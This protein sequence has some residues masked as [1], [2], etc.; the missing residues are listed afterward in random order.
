MIHYPTGNKLID[1]AIELDR[2]NKRLSDIKAGKCDADFKA[3]AEQIIDRHALQDAC[4][5]LKKK[6]TDRF[7]ELADNFS[8]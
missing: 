4:A 6:T 5:E 7:N 3:T 8:I 1:D 2:V